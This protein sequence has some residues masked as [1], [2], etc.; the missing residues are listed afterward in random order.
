LSIIQMPYLEDLEGAYRMGVRIG[1]AAQAF[2]VGELVIAPTEPCKAEE[3]ESFLKGILEG[4]NSSY[5]IQTKNY[6][7]KV[8]LVPIK[9]Y[10]LFQLARSRFGEVF[11]TTSARGKPLDQETCKQIKEIVDSEK[12]INV[13]IGSREGI[14]TGIMRWSKLIVNLCPGIT[15]ATEHGIPAIIAAILACYYIN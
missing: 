13:F 14:P 12:R 2:E 4:R 1:R 7:R 10:D 8:K 3:F 9:I 15:F 6:P 5:R 11:V